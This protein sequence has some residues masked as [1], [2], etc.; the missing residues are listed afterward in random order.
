MSGTLPSFVV[1]PYAMQNT[2]SS[3]GILV[4]PVPPNG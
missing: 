2:P 3:N 4:N 1:R